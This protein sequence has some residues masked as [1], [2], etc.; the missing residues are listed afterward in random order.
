MR[1]ILVNAFLTIL[2]VVV[3]AQDLKAQDTKNVIT[4]RK[5]NVN[6]YAGFLELNLNY[7]R[8]IIVSSQSLSKIR[9]GLGYGSFFV[10]GE[11]YY[12]NGAFVHLFGAKDSHFEV[13]AGVKYMLTNSISNPSFSDQLLPDIFIGYRFEKST[14][15]FTFRAGLNY[16]TIINVGIGYKF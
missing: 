14:G 9:L 10:A 13:T 16:P 2:V 5:N 12:I 15:G 8:N 3:F 4:G 11:G 6:V 1:F 7:E